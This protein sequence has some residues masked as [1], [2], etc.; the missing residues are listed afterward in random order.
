MWVTATGMAQVVSF[1]QPLKALLFIF[2]VL[3]GSFTS[4]SLS[5]PKNIY[6]STRLSSDMPYPTL[7]DRPFFMKKYAPELFL[8]LAARRL[9]RCSLPGLI[10][11]LSP[12]FAPAIW[13]IK[14]MSAVLMGPEMVRSVMLNFSLVA[15]WLL[16]VPASVSVTLFCWALA[17]VH[18]KAKAMRAMFFLFVKICNMYCSIYLNGYLFI[19][20]LGF[21]V[22]R[23][24]P[25]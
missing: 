5:Q 12:L 1:E 10:G 6:W 2:C 17:V 24:E 8:K 13:R 14:R 23:A 4:T 22:R 9:R 7:F 25:V 21:N 11:S 16:N 18:I 3:A 15:I 20:C 19:A